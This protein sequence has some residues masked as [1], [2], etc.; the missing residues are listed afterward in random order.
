MNSLLVKL[1]AFFGD[2]SP[3]VKAGL[4]WGVLATL[5]VAL[6]NAITP[7]MLTWAGPYQP[8]LF[9][10]IPILAGQIGAWAKSDPLRDAGKAA[11]ATPAP[12]AAEAGK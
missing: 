5:A 4:N 1:A 10:A 3:K 12:P 11:Q 8:V 9:A 7:D 6:L 2:I